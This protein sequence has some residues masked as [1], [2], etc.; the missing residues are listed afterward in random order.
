MIPFFHLLT[1][2]KLKGLVGVNTEDS[3]KAIH[4]YQ[5]PPSKTA[6]Q[7]QHTT[8]GRLKAWTLEN[9]PKGCNVNKTFKLIA[10]PTYLQMLGHS[11]TPFGI[12]DD[13]NLLGMQA[14]FN[15]V[16]KALESYMISI[17]SNCPV[18]GVVRYYYHVYTYD[19]LALIIMFSFI[20]VLL[21]YAIS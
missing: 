4:L 1:I 19:L 7:C 3:P 6:P 8:T 21:T 9:L 18:F 10:S 17:G 15:H 13:D 16:Y 20:L 11:K 2:I 14:I 12:P 5:Q